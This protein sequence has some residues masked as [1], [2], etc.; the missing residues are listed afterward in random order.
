MNTLEIYYE[1]KCQADENFKK[2]TNFKLAYSTLLYFYLP[3]FYNYE[4][5]WQIV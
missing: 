1:P 3:K 5:C 2:Q 4:I